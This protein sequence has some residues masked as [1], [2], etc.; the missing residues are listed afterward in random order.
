MAPPTPADSHPIV[1][2][3]LPG[4]VALLRQ[5]ARPELRGEAAGTLGEPGNFAANEMLVR[6]DERLCPNHPTQEKLTAWRIE[7]QRTPEEEDRAARLREAL[8]VISAHEPEFI[9]LERK[10]GQK[11]RHRAGSAKKTGKK[12]AGGTV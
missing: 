4:L 5:P 7:V 3:D 9:A 2:Q 8:D 10:S 11:R 12:P 1:R 6:V